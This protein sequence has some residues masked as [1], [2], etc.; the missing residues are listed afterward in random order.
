VAGPQE[1]LPGDGLCPG[2]VG[3]KEGLGEQLGQPVDV[4]LVAGGGEGVEECLDLAVEARL[5][6][7]SSIRVVSGHSRSARRSSSGAA[8][9]SWRRSA[10]V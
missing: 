10:G 1:R 4:E 3:G 5:G 6:H 9:A 8:A 7:G 2:L